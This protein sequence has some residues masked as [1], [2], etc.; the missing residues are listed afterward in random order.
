MGKCMKTCLIEI[1]DVLELISFLLFYCS[2]LGLGLYTPIAKFL[3][4]D[5]D[6]WYIFIQ[7][8]RA[9]NISIQTRAGNRDITLKTEAQDF[10][11]CGCEEDIQ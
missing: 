8:A 11:A 6:A 2:E 7:C 4:I 5:T 1:I 9:E 3:V 10:K